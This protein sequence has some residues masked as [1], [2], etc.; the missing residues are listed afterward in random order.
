V[1]LVPLE[2]FTH[3]AIGYLAVAKRHAAKTNHEFAV[4]D[5]FWPACR[6]LE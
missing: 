1:H 3:A 6:R 5:D 2:V 4:I